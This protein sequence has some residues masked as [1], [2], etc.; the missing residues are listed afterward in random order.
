M[1]MNSVSG[2][3]TVENLLQIL[4]TNANIKKLYLTT[5]ILKHIVLCIFKISNTAV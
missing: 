5:T 3:R 4:T 1:I 2:N